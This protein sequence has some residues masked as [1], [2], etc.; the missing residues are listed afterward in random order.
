[1]MYG[2]EFGPV[3][4]YSTCPRCD[5]QAALRGLRRKNTDI[6]VITLACNKCHK[7]TVAGFTSVQSVAQ[8][9]VRKK[10]EA[11]KEVAKHPA[12]IRR[13]DAKLKKLERIKALHDLGL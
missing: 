9:E 6:I 1:M 12:T 5:S 2:I 7:H 4:G 8:E 11:M 13:L 3:M 10:L